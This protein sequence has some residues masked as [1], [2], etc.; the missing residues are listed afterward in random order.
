[1]CEDFLEN[2]AMVNLEIF[3]SELNKNL[4][5]VP[6]VYL[7]ENDLNVVDISLLIE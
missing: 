2:R 5:S 7:L 6:V 1:M 3:M 4:L